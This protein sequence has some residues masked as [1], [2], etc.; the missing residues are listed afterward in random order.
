VGGFA[1]IEI[2]SPLNKWIKRGKAANSLQRTAKELCNGME[3]LV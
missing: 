1:D 3:V 2:V